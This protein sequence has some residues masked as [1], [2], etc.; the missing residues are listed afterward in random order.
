M[1]RCSGK[2]RAFPTP[3]RPVVKVRG[4]GEEEDFLVDVDVDIDGWE[5]REKAGPEASEPRVRFEGASV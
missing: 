2:V 4:D 3:P 1:A 5:W